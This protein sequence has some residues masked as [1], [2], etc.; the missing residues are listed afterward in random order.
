[1]SVKTFSTEVLT[2]ADTNT[3]LTNSGLVYVTSASATSGTS[4]SINNCFTST[5]SNYRIVIS[6]LVTTGA[7]AIYFRLRA[8]SADATAADYYYNGFYFATYAS[9]TI[10]GYAGSAITYFDTSTVG[11]TLASGAIIEVLQPQVASRTQF[12]C[13]GFDP[14]SSTGSGGRYASGM[15]NTNNQYDGFTIYNCTFTSVTATVYGYRK[16]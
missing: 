7:A 13:H 10:S 5:Y 8:S 3:Y 4:L 6:N 14:R 12:G 16:A 15:H 11:D 2:S 9:T 1:M